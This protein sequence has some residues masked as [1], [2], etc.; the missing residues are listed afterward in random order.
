MDE[1]EDSV[2]AAEL[3]LVV[4]T[5]VRRV[6]A[7]EGEPFAHAATLGFLERQGPMT[8]SELAHAQFVRPQS[9]AR[10]LGQLAEDELVRF[11]PHPTDGR[12]TL[13]VLTEAGR[14]AV[15]QGRVRRAGWLHEAM[16]TRLSTA[17][18]QVLAQA[19]PLLRRLADD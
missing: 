11:E 16:E 1:P 3:R 15:A 4:G 9:I 6:R 8:A 13:V 14:R 17:E 19:V 2:L 5:L 18:R 7:L 12:K 10:T